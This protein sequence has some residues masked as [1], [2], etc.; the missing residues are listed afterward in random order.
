LG[1]TLTF[2]I[3]FNL[4]PTHIVFTIINYII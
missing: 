4:N 1:T 2:Q 3:I